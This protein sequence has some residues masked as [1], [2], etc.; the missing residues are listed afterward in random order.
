MCEHQYLWL[1][2]LLYPAEDTGR[3]LLKAADRHR[4]TEGLE[5]R[6]HDAL[7]HAEL[8]LIGNLL[9]ALLRI[10]LMRLHNV[11]IVPTK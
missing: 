4:G 10:I 9:A 7:K 8:H 3:K 2:V 5:Q 1:A 6:V 11:L